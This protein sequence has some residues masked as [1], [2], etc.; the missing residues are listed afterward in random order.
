[1]ES[2]NLFHDPRVLFKKERMQICSI[3]K[4]FQSSFLFLSHS[5]LE[6]KTAPFPKLCNSFP[7]ITTDSLSFLNSSNLFYH[8]MQGPGL[9]GTCTVSDTRRITTLFENIKYFHTCSACS[10][11]KHGEKKINFML[12][13]T[14]I[15]FA[16][17][18]NTIILYL[19]IRCIDV[20]L[21]HSLPSL[22]QL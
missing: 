12:H 4:L 11:Y 3:L 21:I 5:E 1:V 7:S 20:S 15:R 10:H 14:T 16:T 17:Q 2:E 8:P 9:P 19:S 6:E 18:A 13:K 22:M